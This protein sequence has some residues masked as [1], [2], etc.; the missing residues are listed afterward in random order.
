M[1]IPSASI[2]F[3]TLRFYDTPSDIE[4]SPYWVDLWASVN[5][6]RIGLQIKTQTFKAA[7]VS[8]YTGKARAGQKKGHKLFKEKFGGKAFFAFPSKGVLDAETQKQLLEEID[9]LE[10]LPQGDFPELP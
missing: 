9:R 5:G 4:G 7:S 1:S 2:V 10:K 3:E 8:I 6:Y